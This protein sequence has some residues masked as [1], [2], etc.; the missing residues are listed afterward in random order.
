MSKTARGFARV[1]ARA[2]VAQTASG[3]PAM[4]FEPFV[5][6]GPGLVTT[7]G[8]VFGSPCGAAGRGYDGSTVRPQH[9]RATRAEI[10][11]AANAEPLDQRLVAPLVDTLEVVEQL[12]ALRHSFSSPRREWL[13]FTWVLKCSVRLV[14]RS[15]RIATWTSGEPVSPALVAYS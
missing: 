8:I 15:D 7:P 9:A 12:A 11:S 4:A 1:R 14:M 2:P 3:D 10:A 6:F 13:S 5:R